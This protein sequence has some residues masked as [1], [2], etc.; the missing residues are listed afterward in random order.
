M[1]IKTRYRNRIDRGIS[2][3]N[4]GKAKSPVTVICRTRGAEGENKL[5]VDAIIY[6]M[7][8]L[9]ILTQE[10]DESIRN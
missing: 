5:D 7:G 10:A 9:Y 3:E 1:E 8:P 6:K 2:N 4:E